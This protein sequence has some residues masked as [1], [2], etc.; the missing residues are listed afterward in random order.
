MTNKNDLIEASFDG[1]NDPEFL[2][3]VADTILA[4]AAIPNLSG[5]SKSQTQQARLL[6]NAAIREL[7]MAR[8][9]EEFDA[10]SLEQLGFGAEASI[11]ELTNLWLD[12]IL[13]HDECCLPMGWPDHTALLQ[14][15]QLRNA[16]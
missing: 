11:S 7:R 15:K 2:I 16:I 3:Q 8:D 12:N 14:A 6:L 9:L 10:R 4:K 1:L 13:G 5:R